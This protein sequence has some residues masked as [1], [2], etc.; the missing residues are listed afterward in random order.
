MYDCPLAKPYKLSPAAAAFR[1]RFPQPCFWLRGMTPSSW[2]RLAFK[3][4]KTRL[5]RTGLFAG[6][7]P[8]IA[9][10][11]VATDA[12]GGPHSRDPRLR[13]VGWA[14]VVAPR[15]GQSIEVL[16]TLLGVIMPPATVP[17]G[18]HMAIIEAI[19]HTTGQMDL[20]T[21][22]KGVLKTLQSVHLRRKASLSGEMSGIRRLG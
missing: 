13:A 6:N 9:D 14:V 22:C 8:D 12:S 3:A 7:T 16:G 11:V 10:L 4:E 2:T 1:K 19:R 20:T 18:E 21:D 17:Q 15:Q 5:E